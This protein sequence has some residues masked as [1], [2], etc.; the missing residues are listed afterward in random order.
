MSIVDRAWFRIDIRALVEDHGIG[1]CTYH[2]GLQS[3]FTPAAV[4]PLLALP[5]L[6]ALLHGA[7]GLGWLAGSVLTSIGMAVVAIMQIA[8]V[9]RIATE[10]LGQVATE[11]GMMPMVGNEL[12]APQET[13][14]TGIAVPVGRWTAPPPAVLKVASPHLTTAR[15]EEPKVVVSRALAGEL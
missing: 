9:S 13:A 2:F 3:R 15:P 6:A 7:T 5:A 10:A 4:V 8:S 14:R 12:K 1:G 11:A